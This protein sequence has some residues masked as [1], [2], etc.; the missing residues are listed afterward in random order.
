MWVDASMDGGAPQFDEDAP[1]FDAPYDGEVP[2]ELDVDPD[3]D[4]GPFF[5]AGPRP[6]GSA[7]DSGFD[8]DADDHLIA[9]GGGCICR[10]GA[11]PR[12]AGLSGSA[13]P[14]VM[15]GLGLLVTLARRRR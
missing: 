11:G 3:F 9:T 4:G 10:A 15:L 2:S 14:A 12:S 5:D 1:G 6:D 8:G 7:M 13:G